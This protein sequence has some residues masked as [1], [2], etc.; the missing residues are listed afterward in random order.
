MGSNKSTNLDHIL[1]R[2]GCM[3][4]SL[5]QPLNDNEVFITNRAIKEIIEF[6]K[7]LINSK[8]SKKGEREKQPR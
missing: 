2:Q 3:L 1:M 4:Q 5:G 6:F 7:Y 8:E